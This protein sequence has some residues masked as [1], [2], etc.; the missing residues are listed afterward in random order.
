[1]RLSPEA[2]DDRDHAADAVASSSSRGGR[3]RPS[4]RRGPRRPSS[5]RPRGRSRARSEPRRTSAPAPRPPCGRAS[6][7]SAGCRRSIAVRKP[8]SFSFASVSA[9][10][11]PAVA[12]AARGLPV[13]QGLFRLQCLGNPGGGRAEGAKQRRDT[14]ASAR[15]R[16]IGA[17]GQG[18]VCERT[19]FSWSAR[20]FR[21][22]A[23]SFGSSTAR[24]ATAS[25]AAFTAPD[26]PMPSV[27]TGTPAGI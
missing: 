20:N 8:S 3:E 1:M 5:R 9:E 14:R 2:L 21:S 19:A 24:M 7:P 26:F 11:L 17:D 13:V 27:P 25:R 6:T 22:F 15:R 10:G 23:R 4:R 18:R 12:S 16:G